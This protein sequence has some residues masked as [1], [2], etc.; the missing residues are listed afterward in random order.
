M[1]VVVLGRQNPLMYCV[2]GDIKHPRPIW[3]GGWRYIKI[4]PLFSIHYSSEPPT[5][6]YAGGFLFT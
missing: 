4:S 6:C 1:A 5:T 3:V 2:R